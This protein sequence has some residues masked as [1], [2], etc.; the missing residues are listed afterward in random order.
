MTN[1]KPIFPWAEQLREAMLRGGVDIGGMP[2][3]DA[4]QVVAGR[5]ATLTEQLEAAR[6]DAKEAETCLE[7]KWQPIETAPRDA[8]I[9]L[10]RPNAA[11]WGKVAPGEWDAQQYHKSPKPYWKMWLKIGGTLESRAWPPTHWMPLPE[12]PKETP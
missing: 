4:M 5:I 3:N 10:Y 7:E 6:R 11:K 12:A 9:I 8:I 1:M 2:V